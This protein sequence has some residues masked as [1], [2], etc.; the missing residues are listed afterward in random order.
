MKPLESYTVSNPSTNKMFEVWRQD[1]NGNRFLVSTF[2][3]LHEAELECKTFEDR[4]HKQHYW[5]KKVE[6]EV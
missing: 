3:T 4:G 5:A 2:P 1:D 6:V